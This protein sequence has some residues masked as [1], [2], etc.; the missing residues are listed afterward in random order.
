[1]DRR[2]IETEE[3]YRAAL[4]AIDALRAGD[5]V[6]AAGT[7]EAADLEKLLALVHAYEAKHR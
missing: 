5:R 6:P 3:D 1:M 7:A 4:S 2:S